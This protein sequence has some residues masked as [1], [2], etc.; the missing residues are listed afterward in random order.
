M[1]KAV[2]H[3]CVFVVVWFLRRGPTHG[4]SRERVWDWRPP[5][6]AL[7]VL[8]SLHLS[9]RDRGAARSACTALALL[10]SCDHHVAA[11]SGVHAPTNTHAQVLASRLML[12]SAAWLFAPGWCRYYPQVAHPSQQEEQK[13]RSVD[14]GDFGH[15]LSA[16]RS[17]VW[18]R[19][20]SCRRNS[21]AVAAALSRNAL[22]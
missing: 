18:A 8:L 1:Q 21:P 9:P 10:L 6:S 5:L 12:R 2:Q 7:S 19:G 3:R 20:V 13:I 4:C 16:V 14:R 22:H 15:G 17:P 11:K